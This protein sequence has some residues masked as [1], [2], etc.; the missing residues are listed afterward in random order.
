MSVHEHS[1]RRRRPETLASLRRTLE[2]DGYGV[3]PPTRE[4]AI[5]AARQHEP[6][7]LLRMSA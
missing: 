7:L 3:V 2:D 1:D 6:D 4:R 5:V